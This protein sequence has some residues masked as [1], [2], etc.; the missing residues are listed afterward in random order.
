[1]IASSG[2]AIAVLAAL[3]LAN[4]ALA[5][6][7]FTSLPTVTV[8]GEYGSWPGG[9]S[10]IYSPYYNGIAPP[11]NTTVPGAGPQQMVQARAMATVCT[12][13]VPISASARNT[14][15]NSD[16][17]SRWLAAQE[18]FSAIQTRGLVTALLLG[19]ATYVWEGQNRRVFVV[20]Y[21][22]ASF[23]SWLVNPGWMTSTVKLMDQPLPNSLLAN[24]AS[25]V[26]CL[27]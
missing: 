18:V 24:P 11:I 7:Q 17:T 19:S 2:K 14:T 13:K 27:G 12:D 20:S 4:P 5:Q 6:S 22:D 16:V 21:G 25:P 23:E 9:G 15:I 10:T 3:A 8:Y 26:T 1:M